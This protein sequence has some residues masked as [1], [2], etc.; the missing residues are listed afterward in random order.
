M[1]LKHGKTLYVGEGYVG[2]NRTFMELK[3]VRG[4]EAGQDSFVLIGP[5][6]N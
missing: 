5:S 1:E 4:I 3:L 2:F 6:W